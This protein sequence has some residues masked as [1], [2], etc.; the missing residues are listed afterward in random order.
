M[1]NILVFFFLVAD[2]SKINAKFRVSEQDIKV[3]LGG[4]ET[5]LLSVR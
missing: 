1:A 2:L 4:N 3:N 5:F